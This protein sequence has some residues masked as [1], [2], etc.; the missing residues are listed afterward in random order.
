MNVIFSPR[1]ISYDDFNKI[2]EGLDNIQ[3]VA[4]ILNKR[5]DF[6][7]EEERYKSWHPEKTGINTW[8]YDQLFEINDFFKRTP[9]HDHYDEILSTLLGDPR[10]FFFLERLY[11]QNGS[12][13]TLSIKPGS[14]RFFYLIEKYCGL[15]RSRS[16]FNNIIIVE[17]IVWNSLS[18]LYSTNADRLVATDVPHDSFWFFAR[19]A[20]LLGIDIYMTVKSP[21]PSRIW[22]IKGMNEQVPIHKNL[23]KYNIDK[24]LTSDVKNFVNNLT[25]SYDMAMP[26]FEKNLRDTYGGQ[27][28]KWSKEILDILSQRSPRV[29]ITTIYNAL[30]KKKAFEAYLDY[31]KNFVLPEKYVVFF[32]QFQPERTTLPEGNTYAQQWLAIRI[33]AEALPDDWH[34]LVK[35]HPGMFR[36]YFDP[37]VRD[38]NFYYSVNSLPRTSLV[39][40][41]TSPFELIDNSIAVSTITGTAGIEALARGK[42]V[43]IFGSAQ[44]QMF[45]GIYQ[46]NNSA[47]VKS[48]LYQIQKGV[49][50]PTY[51]E[52]LENFY[53]VAQNSYKKDINWK[54][55]SD[56]LKCA[57]TADE[58]HY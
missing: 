22:V 31:S 19:V 16:V 51:E 49:E 40:L 4:I 37:K 55:S 6:Q 3:I 11:G 23:N 5:N 52:V 9:Y 57:L 13:R 21:I 26:D 54:I 43:I 25:S 17:Q 32:L 38:T 30:C 7:P 10:T 47:E 34:L 53:W 29:F 28:Y 48:V 1:F 45:K 12:E 41:G 27:F 20:E 50:V 8:T 33:L 18:I 15:C 46:A 56:A 42:P 44:Y 39:P 24:F 35:E 14:S 36:R 58:K 2:R